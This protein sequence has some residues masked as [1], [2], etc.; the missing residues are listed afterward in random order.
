[1]KKITFA[2]L[3]GNRGFFPGSVIAAARE[4]MCCE[5]EI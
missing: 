2:I 3:F 1:M 4:E 5:T